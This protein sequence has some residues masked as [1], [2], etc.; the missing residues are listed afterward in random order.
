MK[1]LYIL[2]L[3]Q[4]YFKM[5]T[6]NPVSWHMPLR[7]TLGRQEHKASLISVESSRPQR[8]YK[9]FNIATWN[10]WTI[11]I[12]YVYVATYSGCTHEDWTAVWNRT[13]VVSYQ[14]RWLVIT[15]Y[16]LTMLRNIPRSDQRLLSSVSL[17]SKLKGFNLSV[18]SDI[19]C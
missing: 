6:W 18:I 8:G 11:W 13:S 19:R 17:Q 9:L 4:M 14:D 1:R 3:L 7:P 2:F 10:W 15:Y 5:P 12:F 16:T